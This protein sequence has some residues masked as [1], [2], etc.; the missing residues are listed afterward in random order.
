[1][2][3]QQEL[4]SYLVVELRKKKYTVYDCGV[5]GESATYPFIVLGDMQQVDSPTKG[6]YLSDVYPTIHIYSNNPSAR[7]ALSGIILDIKNLCNAF[8]M[9]KGWILASISTNIRPDN[10]TTVPLLHGIVEPSFRY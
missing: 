7:G 8:A 2:D 3:R 4:F 1:M 9:Q 6:R 10:T 5:P